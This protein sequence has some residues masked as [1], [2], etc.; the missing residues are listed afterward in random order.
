ML[1]ESRSS[2]A[3]RGNLG[4]SS[5][6]RNPTIPAYVGSTMFAIFQVLSLALLLSSASTSNAGPVV[7]LSYGSFEGNATADLEEFLGIP[8][9]APPYASY[10]RFLLVPYTD[11]HALSWKSLRNLRFAHPEPPLTFDG[12]RQTTRFG[13]ACPQRAMNLSL[14]GLGSR[15]PKVL[16]ISEDCRTVMNTYYLILF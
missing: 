6:S 1:S 5:H 12:V 10:S 4:D 3:K 9:A 7:Q 2:L 8:Y 16:P 13:S 14:P 15:R 11:N